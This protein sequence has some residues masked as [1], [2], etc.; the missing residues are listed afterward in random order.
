[1]V[2]AKG[3]G[4]GQFIIPSYVGQIGLVDV[5]AVKDVLCT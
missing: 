4:F 2:A 3:A 5:C 1:M